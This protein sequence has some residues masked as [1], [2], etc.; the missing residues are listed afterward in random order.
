MKRTISLLLLITSINFS[1]DLLAQQSFLKFHSLSVHD[2]LSQSI[3]TSIAEDSNGIIWVGTR[4]GLNRLIGKEITVFHSEPGDSSSIPSDQ[5]KCLKYG[6]G[7]KLWIGTYNAGL[8]SL[9]PHTGKAGR[10]IFHDS[11]GEQVS[12]A[13]INSIDFGSRNCIWAAAGPDGLFYLDPANGK[14]EVI[15]IA[16]KMS[17]DDVSITDLFVD[18]D[19]IWLATNKY[20]IVHY[21]K[22]EGISNHFYQPGNKINYNSIIRLIPGNDEWMW[23]GTK[24]NFLH[25]INRKTGKSIVFDEYKDSVYH[26]ATL[27][28]ILQEGKDTLW[29][30]TAVGGL[31]LL[32]TSTGEIEFISND[33]IP[34]GIAYNSLLSLYRSSNDILWVGTNGKGLS[35]Y[36]AGTNRFTTYSKKKGSEYELGFESVRSVYSDENWIFFGGYFG[37]NRIDRKTGE[38]VYWLPND[39]GYTFCEVSGNSDLLLVGTEGNG[40]KLIS[41]TRGLV[42]DFGHVSN[43]YYSGNEFNY[44]NLVYDIVYYED[45]KY[46]LGHSGGLAIFDLE[47][48]RFLE[49]YSHSDENGSII[50]GEIKSIV[51][52]SE[53]RIWVGSTSEGIARFFPEDGRFEKV[54]FDNADSDISGQDVLSMMEDSKGQLW[55][56]TSKGLSLFDPDA[57]IV[58]VYNSGTGMANNSVWSIEECKHGFIWCGTNEGISRIDQT[59]GKINN[60]SDLHGL[61]GKEM[62]RGASFRR[63]DGTIFFGGVDGAISFSSDP[64]MFDFPDPVP[65][66]IGYYEYNKPVLPD[67]ILPYSNNLVVPRGVDFF[68]LRITG[69]DFLL[70]EQNVFRYR[71]PGLIDDNIDLE[72]NRLISLVKAKPGNYVLELSVSNDGISWIKDD[73]ALFITLEPKFIQT[74]LAKILGI[75]FILVLVG[76]IVYF[77]TRYLTRQKHTLNRLVEKRTA[78]LSASESMLKEANATKDRFFSILAHDLR[79]PFSSLLGLSEIMADEWDSYS[80]DEK[81]KMVSMIREN[82]TTTF[83]L[84]NNLL[85][86]SRLQ[87]GV[88]KPEFN[89]FDLSTIIKDVTEGLELRLSS[90]NISINNHATPGLTAH[91]DILMTETVIRNIM[92]NAV[93]YTPEGGS[94]EIITE[95]QGENIMI[96]IKDTGLGMDKATQDTLFNLVEIKSTPGTSGEKGTGLGLLVCKE[97]VNLMKGEIGFSSEKGKGSEFWFTIPSS[98]PSS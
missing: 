34:D 12:N 93:K 95:A 16:K 64:S 82:L 42:R 86:W 27:Y 14:S 58:K 98:S 69:T 63:S 81:K 92:T 62:N 80:D 35:Y 24:N 70:D 9:D 78:E 44:L 23:A 84:L 57:G 79:S 48:G 76:L 88:I 85:D 32:D 36:H 68:S 33:D 46:L 7:D 43:G 47:K 67:T 75:V 4:N 39:V 50:K 52:D 65:Q 37:I 71:I 61:P 49:N 55:F 89:D 28:D 87:R 17:I 41:K 53:H 31:Q 8:A 5:I 25:K 56:G 83:R 40:I 59:T 1:I 60:Y 6:P 91:S 45:S 26:H 94:V 20:G 74:T 19:D 30:A 2:G 51:I 54:I 73:T 21:R 90:K 97:F 3:V 11:E 38:T 66:V 72:E 96:T 18:G 10:F 22:D 13:I 77:R 29:L 15:D